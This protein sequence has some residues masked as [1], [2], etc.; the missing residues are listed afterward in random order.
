MGLDFGK[1]LIV[2]L[3]LGNPNFAREANFDQREKLFIY[4]FNAL[5]TP[6]LA[7][8]FLINY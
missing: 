8:T 2:L 7:L 4:L 1:Q 3:Q 6:M 5:Y